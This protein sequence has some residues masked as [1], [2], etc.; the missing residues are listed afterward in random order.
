MFI[1]RLPVKTS[2]EASAMVDKI[3][4]Y[5]Q[6]SPDFYQEAW[7]RKALF[8][9]DAYDPGAGD[10]AYYSN[11][12]ADHYLPQGYDVQKVYYGVTHTDMNAA[13]AAII[14]AINQGALLVNYVGHG[15]VQSWG[16]NTLF[17]VNSISS[18][19]NTGKLPFMVPMTCLEGSF[20]YPGA[21][22]T[23]NSSLA[24]RLVR[25]PGRGAIASFSP[26]G[27]GVTSGHDFLNKG[28]YD[29]I[30][31]YN[32]THIGLAT[33]QA[34]LYLFANSGGLHW[35][36]IDTYVLL[37]DPA[38]HLSLVYKHFL[39]YVALTGIP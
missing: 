5:E 30:F 28:L 39:P 22:G 35:D 10:F 32:M 29:A 11:L 1:G 18:L 20:D 16:M 31:A 3:L 6:I 8:V 36:L 19:N 26:A 15:S 34:K 4:A 25:E 23:D 38:L 37:G 33:T 14:D 13:R 9:A 7:R 17:S 27:F 21:P 12:V 2:A 24:E